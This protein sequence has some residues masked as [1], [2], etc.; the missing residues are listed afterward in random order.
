LFVSLEQPEEEI[1]L[2]WQQICDGDESLYEKVHVLGNEEPDGTTRRLSLSDIQEYV[3][4]LEKSLRCKVG[5]VVI[6]HIGVLDKK[7]KD[8]ENQG[9][10]DICH[11]MKNFAKKTKTFLVMQSQTNR[12]KA[13][14][15]DLELD[16]DSAYGTTLFEWYVDYLVTTWQPLKRVYDTNPEMCCSA[17]KYC[18]IRKKNIK[19]DNIKEDVVYAL[20][21]DVDT[22][23]LRLMTEE[24][25]IKYDTLN[26]KASLLR[27]KDKKLEASRISNHTWVGNESNS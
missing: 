26:K 14:I 4:V 12:V 5:C 8:G 18:K 24:E 15:G 7:T 9:L 13:G 11:Q 25:K 22:E 17:Y 3:G 23:R 10:M 16:K 20:M 21:F 2:R 19:K 27:N 1:A 6:D